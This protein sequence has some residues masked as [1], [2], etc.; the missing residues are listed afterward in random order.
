MPEPAAVAREAAE[1]LGAEMD[2]GLPGCV[3]R[4]L[5]RSRGT[6]AAG[7]A[8]GDTLGAFIVAAADAGCRVVGDFRADAG[9]RPARPFIERHLR[10]QM[11]IDE[12]MSPERDAVID[13]VVA[14]LL[15][16]G[17]GNGATGRA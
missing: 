5:V 6:D 8:N 3:E 13:T 14:V 15:R 10:R 11:G 1:E 4:I 17:S 12:G 2:P 7:L 16:H 9:E